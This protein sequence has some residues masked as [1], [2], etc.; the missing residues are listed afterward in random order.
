MEI[1]QKFKRGLKT[2]LVDSTAMNVI[3][4]PLFAGLET[5][6]LGMSDKLSFNARL[7]G[8]GLT[9][10]G[11]GF[12]A[13]KGRDI[14]RKILNITDKTNEKTQIV[15]DAI[16]G[17][18]WNLV[19]APP[20][21]Y[22]AGVDDIEKIIGGTAISITFGLTSGSLI[23]YAIDFY[24]DLTN[25]KSSERVHSSIRGKSSKFKLGLAAAITATSIALNALVYELT[26]DKKPETPTKSQNI[27]K[28]VNYNSNQ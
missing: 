6:V 14:Y 26:Q 22:A 10:A 8:T 3:C 11:M 25:I 4:N 17:G 24:R 19:I 9:Y 27:E 15:H 21:Y 16:Y 28:I 20:F 5:L 18:L 13:A 12:L 1:P 2:H 23:G 7:L